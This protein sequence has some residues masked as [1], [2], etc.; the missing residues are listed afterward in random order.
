[1]NDRIKRWEQ[2]LCCIAILIIFANPI[3]PFL[4][5]STSFASQGYQESDGSN[6]ESYIFLMVEGIALILLC[7]R[8][9][10]VC[11]RLIIRNRFALC[12]MIVPLLAL[13]SCSWSIVPQISLRRATLFA[14][15]TVIGLYF[16][17]RYSLRQ[18]LTILAWVFAI[19]IWLSCLYGLALPQYAVMQ[20]ISPGAWRGVFGGKNG[21]GGAMALAFS[22]YLIILIDRTRRS[23]FTGL[24]LFMA[25]L[26]MVLAKSS[27]S[28]VVA[29][30]M[31]PLM[32]LYRAFRFSY[33][34]LIPILVSLFIV[35]T[36]STME[37]LDN[38]ALFVSLLGR[39]ITLTGRT[40]IWADVWEAIAQRPWLG[41]GFEGFWHPE[42]HFAADIW[43]AVGWQPTH[44]HNGL[45]HILLS[46]GW[47]GTSI[48]LITF[49][50]SVYQSL[51]L[52]RN[53]RTAIYFWPIIFLTF[54]FI[55]NLTE[56][57]AF[58][59]FYWVLYVA[60][61]LL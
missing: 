28:I 31:L 45:L 24:H 46:L 33:G 20:G 34:S 12:P 42:N 36:V 52:V 2:C 55:C 1:V 61:S 17:T 8:W 39:D 41:Y 30:A 11:W 32:L 27:T 4:R 29:I 15:T 51:R 5:P 6:L 57:R 22:F 35:I 60:I 14:G 49:C 58:D 53:T 9:R 37:G 54:F 56:S 18:Q 16:G 38:M 19:A 3:V 21:L 44:P 23:W 47:I 43:Q 25:L 59:Y 13:I 40:P 10:D 50:V 7:Y 48:Y 26:L